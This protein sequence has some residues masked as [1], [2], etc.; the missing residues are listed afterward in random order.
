MEDGVRSGAHRGVRR[1]ERGSGSRSVSVSA[2]GS[3]TDGGERI[4]IEVRRRPSCLV[5][6]GVESSGGGEGGAAPD[7]GGEM[8]GLGAYY[9]S[10]TQHFFNYY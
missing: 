5:G 6:V 1:G 3:A 10:A 7:R 8:F 9:C 2:R 4:E